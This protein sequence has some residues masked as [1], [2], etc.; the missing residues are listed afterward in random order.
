M[1]EDPEDR[2]EEMP[3][4]F[5]VLNPAGA[6]TSCNAFAARFQD[7]LLAHDTTLPAATPATCTQGV[8]SSQ[9]GPGTNGNTNQVLGVPPPSQPLLSANVLS[10]SSTSTVDPATN[11]ATDTGLAESAGVNVM[12][13]LVTAD[14]IRGV[15]TANA[16]G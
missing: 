5:T 3:V 7:A 12:N 9:S 13:G 15:A 2:T 10:A 8:C 14:A 4:H 11:T 1:T 16:S 6:N